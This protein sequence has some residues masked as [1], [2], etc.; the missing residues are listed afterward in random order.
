MDNYEVIKNHTIRKIEIVN[1]KQSKIESYVKS[2]R[3]I[4]VDARK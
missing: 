3:L 4:K 1:V 2:G